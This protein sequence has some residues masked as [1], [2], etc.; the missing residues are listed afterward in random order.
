MF[1]HKN[2]RIIKYCTY[3]YV[4]VF[5]RNCF[6]VYNKLIILFIIYK[7][8]LITTF[9]KKFKRISYLAEIR[10]ITPKFSFGRT[11]VKSPE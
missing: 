9:L 8:L 4:C 10:K 6:F 3:I 5:V 11:L 2:S 7:Y 1:L